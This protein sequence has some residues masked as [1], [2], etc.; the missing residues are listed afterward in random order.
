MKQRKGVERGA[1]VGDLHGVDN[2]DRRT[3]GISFA[4]CFVPK[5][6]RRSRAAI[7]FGIC[8]PLGLFTYY[9]G[10]FS[11]PPAETSNNLQAALQR[12]SPY[13]RSSKI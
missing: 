3:N 12:E 11:P 1:R 10:L 9:L 8:L 2:L 7:F 6:G 4:R 5:R 13:L